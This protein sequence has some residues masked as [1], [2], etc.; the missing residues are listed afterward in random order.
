MESGGSGIAA[1][2]SHHQGRASKHEHGDTSHVQQHSAH[3][4]GGRKVGAL[5]VHDVSGQGAGGLV[6]G[7]GDLARNGFAVQAGQDIRTL[8]GGPLDLV[9]GGHGEGDRLD[10]VVARR[11]RGLGQDVVAVVETGEG[12]GGVLA[13]GELLDGLG[14]AVLKLLFELE[15]GALQRFLVLVDLVHDDLVGEDD[16]VVPR[17]LAGRGALAA[18]LGVRVVGELELGLVHVALIAEHG[19]LGERGGVVDGDLGVVLGGGHGGLQ[20]GEHNIRQ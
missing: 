17:G 12:E 3:A 8:S 15:R 13:R 11:G 16:D 5:L 18:L 19:L 20:I 7:E 2:Q 10:G 6:G 4:T 9:I 1:T 14:A